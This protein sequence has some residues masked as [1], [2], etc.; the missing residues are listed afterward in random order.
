M[1][2]A[3]GTHEGGP[4]SMMLPLAPTQEGKTEDGTQC[5]AYGSYNRWARIPTGCAYEVWQSLELS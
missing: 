3:E 1:P 2:S 5:G 4:L